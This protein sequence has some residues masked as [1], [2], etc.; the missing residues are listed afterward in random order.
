VGRAKLFARVAGA[1]LPAQPFPVQQVRAGQF[2]PQPGAA[3]PVDRF[4]VQA[5]GGLTVAQQR[6]A[7]RLDTQAEVGPPA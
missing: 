3:Q 7:A 1:P 5:L 6:A 2:G 4:P